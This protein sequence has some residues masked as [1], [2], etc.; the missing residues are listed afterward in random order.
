VISQSRYVNIISGVGAGAVVGQR[1]LIM[2]IIT[3]NPLL[4]PGVVAEFSTSSAVGNY[5]GQNSEEYNRANAYLSFISKN[6]N[7]PRI[8]SF[9]RWVNS[10]IPA[11]VI[12]DTVVKNLTGLKAVTAGTLTILS[13]G[14]PVQITS[15]NFSG[16][17]DLTACAAILQTAIRGARINVL[18][19]PVATNAVTST[20]GG[21][22]A[23]NTYYYKVTALDANGETIGSNEVSVTTTGTTSSN[24]V[25]FTMPANAASGKVYR[26]T[27]TNAENVYFTIGATDTQFV[28]TGTAG[29]AGT[30][31]VTNTTGTP[32]VQ[33]ATATVSYNTN[34]SQFTLTG[35]TPGTGTL[36]VVLGGQPPLATDVAG[37]LGWGTA[38]SINV[39]GQTADSALNSVTKSVNVSNNFGSLIFT[40]QSNLQLSDITAIAAWND[41]QNNTYL[42]SVAVTSANAAAV[43]A[44]VIGYSGCSLNLLS[45]TQPN[46]YVEQCPCEILG[47]TD[48][49]QTNA[50]QNYM[51]YSFPNR[52]ITVSDDT[53]ANQMDAL[54]VN[55]IGLTQVNGVQVAFYQR[56]LLTGNPQT[57]AVDTNVYCNEMWLKSAFAGAIISFLLA[58]PIVSAD[59]IGEGQVFGI[60]Q[61][62]INQ[63]KDNGTVSVGKVLT[64]QQ[65]Q[66]ITN[67]S[68][69]PLAWRQVQTIGFWL[70]VTF[71]SYV[72]T[73]TQ[74]TEW[75]AS[76]LFIYSKK[77]AIRFVDGRDIMI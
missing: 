30:V 16:A 49:T 65:Q 41:S 32:D 21:T 45:T 33:L 55:Y 42:F 29:T 72:N 24:T 6:I 57:A 66:Y 56:G 25:N 10:S 44:A 50:T 38:G 37:F 34:T 52:N 15:L 9:S 51:F 40:T 27:A 31:P 23:A 73:N 61:P 18:A 35:S 47:A 5:F 26:G 71:S 69:S 22:L 11:Q 12:G 43:S 7:S 8:I 53:T 28:D 75:K 63:A 59:E 14:N 54:R 77:D 60:M 1:N 4:P 70:D 17:A 3:Q 36:A 76:Y 62:V 68:G 20:A 19:P 58:T 64:A 39:T 46:D 74:L 13:N 67:L 48:Y 2:R